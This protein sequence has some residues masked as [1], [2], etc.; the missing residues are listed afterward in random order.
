M[1]GFSILHFISANPARSTAYAY[2]TA[3]PDRLNIQKASW[4]TLFRLGR[5]GLKYLFLLISIINNCTCLSVT[6]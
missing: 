1:Q 3:V 2:P 5:C 4:P 6:I